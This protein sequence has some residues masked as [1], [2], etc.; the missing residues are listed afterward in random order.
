MTGRIV[1]RGLGKAYRRYASPWARLAEWLVPGSRPRHTLAWV[2]RGVDF[3]IRPGEAVGIV[4]INGAGKSTL[5]KV[6]AATTAPTAGSVEVAG[7][8]AAILEL[9]LGF[10]P[11]FSGLQNVFVAGQLMGLGES[12][13]RARL[14]EIEAFAEIGGYLHEPVR[15]YST[16]MQVRLAFSVATCV[17]PDILIV[18]EALSVGDAY[19]QFKSFDRIRQFKAAGTTLL[20]VSHSEAV[21]KSICDRALLLD[22][23]VLVRDGPPDEVMDYYNAAIAKREADY[24]IRTSR[25]EGIAVT[26]SGNRKAE[27][28]GIDLCSAAGESIRAAGVGEPV[29]LRVRVAAREALPELTVGF[30]IRDVLGNQV[31]GTNSHHLG[32]PLA[33]IGAG[34]TLTVDFAIAAL[35]LGLGSY[36]VSVAAHA[37]TTHLSGNYDWWDQALA[38]QVVPGRRAQSIGVC[39]LVCGC[40]VEKW[41]A[42]G[43]GTS[44]RVRTAPAGAQICA[45]GAGVPR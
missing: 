6:I 8:V 21:V 35:D 1:A 2:L 25:A 32:S 40:T 34:E 5:L 27:V 7:R 23:G 3:A 16:G 24:E 9:G 33:G 30:L 41:R 26:R 31:F 13:I 43:A 38:F 37:D 20:F 28:L 45:H 17:R 39:A 18:D 15:T 11:D 14:P 29:V 10:H 44:Q 4:G 42:D 22:G 12:D 36:H 19:F